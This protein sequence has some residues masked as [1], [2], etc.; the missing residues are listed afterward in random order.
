MKTSVDFGI[1]LAGIRLDGLPLDLHG[2]LMDAPGSLPGGSTVPDWYG[3]PVSSSTLRDQSV[4]LI[5]NEMNKVIHDMQDVCMYAMGLD[6]EREHLHYEN[7]A[8]LFISYQISG[9]ELVACDDE[10]LGAILTAA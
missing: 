2:F 1:A 5:R 6:P 8:R 9:E 10:T 7:A 4:D 3:N